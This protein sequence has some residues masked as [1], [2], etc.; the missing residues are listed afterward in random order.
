MHRVRLLIKQQSK[1]LCGPDDTQEAVCYQ[2]SEPFVY[3]KSR[4]VARLLINGTSACTGWLIG[5]DGHLMTNEHCVSNASQANNVTVE[6]MAEGNNCSTDCRTWFGCGGTIV[7]TSTTLVKVNS[8]LDYALLQLPTN[9][10]ATYGFLQ[11]RE[12]GA[13]QG[14][15]IYIPQHP[16]AW[17]KRIALESTDPHDTGGVARVYSVNSQRCNGTGNDIG[18]YADTQPGSSG[19]PVIGYN[20]NL[21]VALHHCGSCPNRGVPIQEIIADLG[22]DLPNNS[23]PLPPEIIGPQTICYSING[24]TYSLQNGESN[25]WNVSSNL[26]ILSSSNTSITV[27]PTNSSTIGAGFIEAILPLETIREDI[28]IGA[29]KPNGFVSVIVDPW[30]GRIKARVEPV[31]D[32]TGYIW[33]LDGVQYTGPGMNSDYVTMPI[34]RNNCTIPDYSIGVR[35]INP[36]GTSVGHFELHENPCYEGEYYY[37]YSPNPASE[38]L[39]V[40]RVNQSDSKS[41]NKT[42]STV[43]QYRLHDFNGNLVQEGNLSAK[44][45]IDVSKLPDGRYI[46]IIQIDK[47]NRETHHIIIK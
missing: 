2:N 7:A 12:V 26:E 11:L 37:S 25:G 46:L 27:K 45:E 29:H 6:F 20:D 1:A 38:T 18:Y 15:R 33:Y 9:V 8:N 23:L 30:L 47:N 17:G 36:C 40:E 43:H 21:V 28:W 19:S 5:D 22:D 35:A 31:Q 24:T 32:A 34:P 44:T 42:I 13:A 41:N 16:Q 14:E 4:A 3:D 10:S 39:T